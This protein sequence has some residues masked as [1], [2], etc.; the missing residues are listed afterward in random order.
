[1]G[2]SPGSDDGRPERMMTMKK[3]YVVCRKEQRDAVSERFSFLWQDMFSAK[4]EEKDTELAF[5]VGMVT[6]EMQEK[7]NQLEKAGVRMVR[8]NDNLI[9]EEL[10]EKVLYGKV[11]VSKNT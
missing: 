6:P 9:N 3:I 8:V 10:Y 2:W 4:E 5:V 7:I 11:G 1:M